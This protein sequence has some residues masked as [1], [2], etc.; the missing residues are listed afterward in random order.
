[1]EPSKQCPAC[2]SEFLV[3]PGACENCG[4]PFI[5]SEKEKSLFIAQHILKKGQLSDTRDRIKRARIIL[6]II[7][8]F[9]ILSPVVASFGNGVQGEYLFVGIFLGIVF[10]GFGFLAYKKPFIAILIPL[11]LLLLLYTASAILDPDTLFNG[12]I[13]KLVF[14]GGLIYALVSIVEAE[15]I[16]RESKFMQGQQYK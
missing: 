10:I 4:F 15:K 1:M 2:K 7:G 11:L 8:G 14:L 12:I 3:Q 6:W 13:L 16:R 5:G 9:N